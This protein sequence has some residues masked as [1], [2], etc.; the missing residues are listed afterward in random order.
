MNCELCGK[1]T[2]HT[3]TVSIENSEIEVCDDCKA[4]G[5]E[6]FSSDK[7][8]SSK[9]RI[10]KRIR[11]K[12]KSARTTNLDDNEKKELALDY[13]NRIERARMEKNLTQEELAKKLSEKKSVIAKLE[14]SDM[15]PS[16]ALRRKLERTLDIELMEE[17]ESPSTK[18]SQGSEGLTI[19]D[20]IDQES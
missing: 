13:S 15:R 9:K 2:P 4:Y 14:R 10:L 18:S 19:G 11:E 16:D 3:T 5:K 6:I 7:A 1:E 20:L 17:I 12:Q 8:T